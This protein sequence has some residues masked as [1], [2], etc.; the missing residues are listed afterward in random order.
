MINDCSSYVASQ[1]WASYVMSSCYH[2]YSQ[3]IDLKVCEL[4]LQSYT[5]TVQQDK[6]TLGQGFDFAWVCGRNDRKCLCYAG[7]EVIQL[8]KQLFADKGVFWRPS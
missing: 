8:H 5:Y 4:N 7:T 3:W 6:Q 2:V 1:L